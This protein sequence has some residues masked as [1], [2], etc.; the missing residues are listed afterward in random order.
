MTVE[1][2]FNNQT[3]RSFADTVDTT[4]TVQTT[5]GS[6][7]NKVSGSTSNGRN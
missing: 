1:T 3:N 4:V 7:T 2:T 6:G 5:D